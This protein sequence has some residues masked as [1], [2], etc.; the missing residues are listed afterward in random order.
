MNET[1]F[2]C[3][4]CNSVIIVS[5]DLID[6]KLPC[7]K[8]GQRVKVP[9][10]E[11]MRTVQ[12]VP[13]TGANRTTSPTAGMWYYSCEEQQGQQGGPVGWNELQRLA[14]EGHLGPGDL[15]WTEGWGNWQTAGSQPGFAFRDSAGRGSGV[16]TAGMALAV[17][18]GMLVMMIVLGLVWKF[19]LKT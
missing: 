8:C 5:T 10:P 17:V 19:V 4:R 11:E 7:P 16:S 15:L 18:G 3:P 13:L 9:M 12:G 2:Q 14:S 1:Q 6:T